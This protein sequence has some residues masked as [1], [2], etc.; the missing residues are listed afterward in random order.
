MLVLSRRMNELI[1]IG[2]ADDLDGATL[3]EIFADGDIQ[4]RLIRIAKNRVSV[5]IEAPSALKI[6]RGP[7][8]PAGHGAARDKA[9]DP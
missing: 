9:K 7:S 5:A 4:I 6:R 8:G 2:P 1:E 3:R